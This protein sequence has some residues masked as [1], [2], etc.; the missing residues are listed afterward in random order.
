[1]KHLTLTLLFG[2]LAFAQTWSQPVRE[3]ER[4]A[5]SAV[6]TQATA[7][8]STLD[9]PVS[10]LLYTVPAGKR[11]VIETVTTA[12]ATPATDSLLRVLLRLSLNGNQSLQY[13][14]FNYRGTSTN[15]AKIYESSQSIRFYADS[16]TQVRG[17]AYR[18]SPLTVPQG[19]TFTFAGYLESIP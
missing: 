11:L 8:W 18:D 16:G 13:L 5:K 19:C 4:P 2:A 10:A 17:E 3:V 6:Q 7:T 15:G 1:M 14:S 9:S 12:C